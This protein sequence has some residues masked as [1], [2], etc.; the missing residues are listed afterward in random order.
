MFPKHFK[1]TFSF[2]VQETYGFVP[3]AYGF[4]PIGNQTYVPT[5][6]KEPNN[7]L[8]GMGADLFRE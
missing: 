4:E 2:T 7:V 8:A 1:K 3:M 5:T 6:S